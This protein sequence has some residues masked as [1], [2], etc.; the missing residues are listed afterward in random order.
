[1]TNLNRPEGM[2]DH[3]DSVG[4][5]PTEEEIAYVMA[6]LKPGPM[7][8]SLLALAADPVRAAQREARA[9]ER[10]ARD[11]AQLGQYRDANAA[12]ADKPVKAVFIGDSITEFWA[13]AD[14]DLFTGGVVGRGISG[15]TSPQMLVRFMADVIAL[16]PVVVHLL[17][18]ANDIVGNTGPSTPQDYKN[19]ILAMVTLAQAH[20]VK[21]IVGSLTPA[22]TFAWAPQQGDPRARIAE[23]NAWLA[24]LARERGLIWADYHS[25]L[26][27][28][29]DSMRPEFTRDGLHPGVDGYAVMRPVARA[30][31]AAALG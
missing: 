5:G 1:M 6:S 7:D 26:K 3:L 31:L 15:Q 19:N 21:V 29:D 8:P 22:S 27:A 4:N 24:G 23:L 16:K 13:G 17:C 28:T 25:V 12:L 18:G 20:G 9:V 10:R 2:V 30:A 14:P 11:W